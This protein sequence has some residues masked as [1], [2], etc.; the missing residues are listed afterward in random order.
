MGS[1][2]N[3][4]AQTVTQKTEIDPMTEQWRRSV[5][6]EGSSLF[7]QGPQQF[8]P[9]Q[10]VAGMSPQTTQGLDMMTQSAQGGAVGLPQAQGAMMR[11]MSGFMP[12]FG[13]AMGAAGGQ[14]N[15]PWTSSM[16]GAATDPTTMGV[17]GLN[18]FSE[19][20]I[21]HLQGL[22]TRGADQITNDLNARFA[23]AGRTGANAAYGG[24]LGGALGDLYTGIMAPGVEAAQNRRLQASGQLAGIDQADRDAAM[25]GYGQA[26]AFASDDFGRRLTGAGMANDMFSQSNADARGAAA[27]LPGL[28]DYG[29]QPGQTMLGV[30]G[31]YEQL[32]QQQI[33]ADRERFDFGQNAQW[34]NLSRFAAMMNGLPDFSS[35]TQTTSGPG[36]SR[37]MGLLGGAASGASMG[38]AFGPWGTAIGGGIGGLMG[39]FG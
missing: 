12:G 14:M 27:M 30:G 23:R 13:T 1:K 19:G 36:R 32:Q 35:Q 28:Y 38:S 25:Q 4:A 39:L 2:T 34:N 17:E 29:Q 15:N 21:D 31:A 18:S 37:G 6:N 9:G 26:G 20:N 7:G 33:D 11:G 16:V 5:F 10:T 8:Y 22:Y 3:G 24:A